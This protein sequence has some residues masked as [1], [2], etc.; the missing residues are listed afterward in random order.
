MKIYLLLIL[1]PLF[2]IS[3]VV[4]QQKY[5]DNIVSD[6][7]S[8]AGVYE[9]NLDLSLCCDSY[10]SA[11]GTIVFYYDG[12]SLKCLYD[13][14]INN[15]LL[16]NNNVF[17]YTDSYEGGKVFGKFVKDDGFLYYFEE[18]DEHPTG[19]TSFLKKVGDSETARKLYIDADNELNEFKEFEKIF[20]KAFINRNEKE[21]L[22]MINLPFY[23]KRK[24]WDNPVIFATETDVKGLL[25]TM[26]NTKLF[27][28]SYKHQ[29]S[30]KHFRGIYT[31]LGDKMFFYFQKTGLVF[32]MVSVTGVYG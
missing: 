29:N 11:F 17:T 28:G 13:G 7:S 26:L 9:G 12:V 14:Q 24:D 8:Y 2:L 22:S 10:E 27:E 5:K 31:I 23:D 18:S 16:L 25:N 3:N 15:D 30:D 6:I 21:V 32:K 4:A 19:S 20:R 1:V